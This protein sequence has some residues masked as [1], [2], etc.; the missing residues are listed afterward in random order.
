M[1]LLDTNT[2]I[3]FFKQQGHVAAHLRQ[4]QASQI[5]LPAVAIFELEYGLLR[6]TKPDA[7]QKGM[8]AVCAAYGLYRW[9][10]KAPNRL[11]G[12]GTQWKWRAP[13][14]ARQTIS[15]QALRWP[16]T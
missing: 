1:Y 11:P 15:S 16:T 6:S 10:P 14:L 12:S 4:A 5:A 3:Y 2:L 7:Q 13:P 8:N 9:T